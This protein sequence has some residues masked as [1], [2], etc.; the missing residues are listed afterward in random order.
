MNARKTIRALQVGLALLALLVFAT[1]VGADLHH[2]ESVNDSHCVF[3]HL[4]HQTAGQPET[5]ELVAVLAPLASLPLPED[6]GLAISPV[7]SDT[8]SRAPP[9]A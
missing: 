1:V 8:S 9:S 2:H 3:C 7:F 6:A 5:T 4:G